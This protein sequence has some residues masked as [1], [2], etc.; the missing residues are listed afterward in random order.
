MSEEIRPEFQNQNSNE[1]NLPNL[2]TPEEP[3]FRQVWL[4]LLIL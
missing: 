4:F 3:V 1:P 2:N